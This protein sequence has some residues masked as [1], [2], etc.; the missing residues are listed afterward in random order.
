MHILELITIWPQFIPHIIIHDIVPFNHLIQLSET[1]KE[2]NTYFHKKFKTYSLLCDFNSHKQT[3]TI[4]SKQENFYQ[5]PLEFQLFFEIYR[6]QKIIPLLDIAA[7]HGCIVI[8]DYYA[9]SDQYRA[10]IKAGLNY[11]KDAINNAALYGHLDVIEWFYNYSKYVSDDEWF[12]NH[13]KY[14]YDKNQLTTI[15]RFNINFKFTVKALY[16]ATVHR[17]IKILDWFYNHEKL[18]TKEWNEE[19]SHYLL[20][21]NIANHYDTEILEWFF[22]HS[23]LATNKYFPKFE[24]T[25]ELIDNASAHGKINV[26]NWFYDKYSANL[27]K[28]KYTKLAINMASY[29]GNIAS[30]N[31]WLRHKDL[32]IELKY[33]SAAI[34][35]CSRMC[36]IDTLD[37]WFYS[38][39]KL[40]YTSDTINFAA[41]ENDINILSWW[42]NKYIYYDLEFKNTDEAIEK[43]A[44]SHHISVLNWFIDQCEYSKKPIAFKYSYDL[45]DNMALEG[46][47]LIL[48]WFFEQYS[49]KIIPFKFRN[50]LHNASKRS[51]FKVLE[52]FHDKII[53]NILPFIIPHV[54]ENI[55]SKN[56]S[57][58]IIG[59]WYS[60][61]LIDL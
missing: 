48:N 17:N 13:L 59:W 54:I 50:A 47:L 49:K 18:F 22:N 45:L 38:G 31:W 52:W 26:L 61:K 23:N 41:S 10:L 42:K 20:I 34:D 7:T 51:N 11:S 40:K 56:Y 14:V 32:G 8:L 6:F 5:N 44:Q 60:S 35:S 37:W 16:N 33:S 9:Y 12:K 30:L 4:F 15:K 28:F 24:Y 36:L 57:E 53:N 21:N 39:L 19:N 2:L 25:E 55:R 46:D 3:I 29:F 1:C 27:L 58:Y 43:A